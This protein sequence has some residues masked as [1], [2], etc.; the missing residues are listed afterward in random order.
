MNTDFIRQQTTL[1][2]KKYGSNVLIGNW[3]EERCD[4]D[5]RYNAFYYERKFGENEYESRTQNEMKFADT[6]QNWMKFRGTDQD[7]FV[8]MHRQEYKDP[9]EQK[10][11]SELNKFVLRKGVFEQ[12]PEQMEQYRER[13][14][15]SK[16]TFDRTYLGNTQQSFKDIVQ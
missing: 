3:Q 4:P 13:W 1:P 8:T 10:R 5:N 12:N 16:Q 11:T 14:T 2:E 15:K 6:K 7:H 9:K